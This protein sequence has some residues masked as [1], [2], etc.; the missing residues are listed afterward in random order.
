[1][2]RKGHWTG[3]P[4]EDRTTSITEAYLVLTHCRAPQ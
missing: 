4:L 1:M 2:K 3:L